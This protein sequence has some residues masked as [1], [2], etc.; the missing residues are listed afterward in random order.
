V[1]YFPA[2]LIWFL[3]KAPRPQKDSAQRR[4][5]AE[6]KVSP[7]FSKAGGG[8]AAAINNL[9]LYGGVQYFSVV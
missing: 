7:A 6:S 2:C 8:R 3:S 5:H 4:E 1:Q 9:I